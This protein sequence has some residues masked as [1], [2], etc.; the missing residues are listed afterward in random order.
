MN[1]SAAGVAGS[2]RA[3]EAARGQP[4][5]DTMFDVAAVEA[6]AW[7][8]GPYGPGDQRGTFNEVTPEKT[9]QALALLR[10]GEPVQ[11]YSLAET[12]ENG[13]PAWGDR[14]YEQRL[15]VT[16]YTPRNDFAGIL[17]D[18]EPQDLGRKSIHEERVSLTYNMGTKINGLHHVGVADML[19]NGFKGPEI[20]ATWG[21]TRLGTE[22]M[23]PIVTRGVVVDVVGWTV[24]IG[25]S[26]CYRLTPAGRPVLRSRYRIT[27]EDIEA[28]L[29]WEGIERP[30]GPGDAVLLR[31]GWR[32]LIELDPERYLAA[33]PPGPYLR[34]CR[35]LAARRPALLGSDTWCFET[36]DPDVV[37]GYTMACHQELSTRFGIRIGEAVPTDVLA[38]AGIY[39]FVFCLSPTSARGAVASNTPPLALAQPPTRS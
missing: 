5:D 11:T 4:F 20:A 34:E 33:V 2:T 37:Q 12:M 28:T 38:D 26:D 39:E 25:R 14:A 1:D 35:Y 10:P 7:V 18:A 6:G 36:V 24:A 31:T 3:T 13:F 30:I 15:V 22:T 27:V 32:E 19:Y 23:G 29:A 8:P 9:A 21:T 16:G 17:T